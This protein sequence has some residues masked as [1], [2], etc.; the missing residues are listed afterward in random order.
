VVC[1]VCEGWSALSGLGFG[2]QVWIQWAIISRTEYEIPIPART[3]AYNRRN[4]QQ[5]ARIERDLQGFSW[6]DLAH[7]PV[8]LVSRSHSP[9]C[10]G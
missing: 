10:Y 2:V 1:W 6:G 8:D 5:A 3:A 7:L 9:W 4:S